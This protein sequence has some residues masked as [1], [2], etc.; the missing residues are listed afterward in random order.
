MPVAGEVYVS[1]AEMY[2]ESMAGMGDISP[3][4]PQRPSALDLSRLGSSDQR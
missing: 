2:G 1:I 3:A 4:Y